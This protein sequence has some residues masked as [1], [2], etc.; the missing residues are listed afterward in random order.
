M[1]DYSMAM[2]KMERA[3]SRAELAAVRTARDR[4]LAQEILQKTREESAKTS[5]YRQSCGRMVRAAADTYTKAE[6]NTQFG[7]LENNLED[8]TAQLGGFNLLDVTAVT[9]EKGYRSKTGM[10]M[11]IIDSPKYVLVNQIYEVQPG[12]I[13]TLNWLYSA[14][15]MYDADKRVLQNIYIEQIPTSVEIPENCAFLTLFGHKTQMKDLMLVRGRKLP[16]EYV[17]YGVLNVQTK[18]GNLN[19]ENI[20]AMQKPLQGVHWTAIGDSLTSAKTL[21]GLASGR[22]NYVDFVSTD[23]GLTVTNLG[24]GGTGYMKNYNDFGTF[25]DRVA[26]VPTDTDL[27]TVFGSFNDYEYIGSKLGALGDT[28]TDTLYGCMHNFF[29]AL[30]A[31]CPAVRVGVITP[32]PWRLICGFST[33]TNGAA[34]A[35]KYVTALMNTAKKGGLPVLDLYHESELRPWD[36]AFCDTYFKDD[37]GDGTANGVHPLEIAHKRFLAPKIAD[38]VQRIYRKY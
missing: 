12:Q 14:V 28:G 7:K 2:Q 38:F 19:A 25:A 10:L 16:E 18:Q 15:Q 29:T 34:Y 21:A 6:L 37:T 22:Q 3:A 20:S 4:Q 27:L 8:V 35:E 17:P 31:R 13:Y 24:I 30:F 33:E 9:P 11:E 23:L 36:T 26:S 5:S 1:Y 32:T